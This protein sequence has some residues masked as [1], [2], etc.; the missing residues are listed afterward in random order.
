MLESNSVQEISIPAIIQGIFKLVK[1]YSKILL[2]GNLIILAL[3]LGWRFSKNKSFEG[4]S[5]VKSNFIEYHFIE[6]MVAPLNR[7]MDEQHPEL[8]AK[9]L[10][11]DPSMA[12]KFGSVSTSSL[13]DEEYVEKRKFKDETDLGEYELDVVFELSVTSSEPDLLPELKDAVLNYLANQEYIKRRKEFY[14]KER[15][16]INKFLEKD[17]LTMDSIKRG[18]AQLT[19]PNSGTQPGIFIQDLGDFYLG[20]TLV[21][22]EY[23]KNKYFNQFNKAFEEVSGIEIYGKYVYPRW[24]YVLLIIM[25]FMIG[26]SVFLIALLESISIY[27]KTEV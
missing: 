3:G 27:R 25:G 11:I 23:I 17:L 24:T 19:Q 4:T 26:F 15:L 6:K 13:I 14:S 12:M 10:G 2:V 18:L 9:S 16:E 5:I 21:Y 8:L 1:R 7:H 20:G 22:E